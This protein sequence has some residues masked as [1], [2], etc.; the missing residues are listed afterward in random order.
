MKGMKGTKGMKGM[1]RRPFPILAAGSL[2]LWLAVADV[3]V[4][5]FGEDTLGREI[6]QRVAAPPPRSRRRTPPHDPMIRQ[7]PA[8]SAPNAASPC[9]KQRRLL[10]HRWGTDEHR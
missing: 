1:K 9:R 5:S 2:V 8:N 10:R 4:R 7:R 3:F 6:I